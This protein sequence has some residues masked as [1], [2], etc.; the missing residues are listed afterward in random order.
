MSIPA[1]CA[2]RGERNGWTGDAAF[3]A[4]SEMFDFGTAAFFSNYLAMTVDAQSDSG[5]LEWMAMGCFF[6]TII[7]SVILS[8]DISGLPD[9][10][11]LRHLLRT[12]VRYAHALPALLCVCGVILLALGYGIDIGE[13][14][15]CSFAIFGYVMA[16]AFAFSTVFFAVFMRWKRQQLHRRCATEGEKKALEELALG[17]A[18]FNTWHDLLPRSGLGAVTPAV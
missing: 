7:A 17:R 11:L 5:E 3:G 4:E 16:P 15:G 12:Q 9:K 14:N 1:G 6:F 8:M 2:G 13:R 18:V 10:L